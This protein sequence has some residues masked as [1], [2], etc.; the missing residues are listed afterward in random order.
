MLQEYYIW[1][2]ATLHVSKVQYINIPVLIRGHQVEGKETF[3][4][5]SRELASNVVCV[6]LTQLT[7]LSV[8]LC[9]G[10]GGNVSFRANATTVALAV[11]DL[12]I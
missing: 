7:S 11:L 6:C 2:C 5:H 12:V 3:Y 9:N 1:F 4:N 10:K 8:S